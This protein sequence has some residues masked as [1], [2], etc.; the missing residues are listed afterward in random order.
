M[1]IH[2]TLSG[3]SIWFQ[4]TKWHQKS[5]YIKPCFI[6]RQKFARYTFRL[7]R[8]CLYYKHDRAV[9]LCQQMGCVE[10]YFIVI[11][12]ID[13]GCC[14]SMRNWLLA[15]WLHHTHISACFKLGVWKMIDIHVGWSGN[16]FHKAL[17]W[18]TK[19]LERNFCRN[20]KSLAWTKQAVYNKLML[21]FS[22]IYK[23]HCGLPGDSNVHS[24]SRWNK[25]LSAVLQAHSAGIFHFSFWKCSLVQVCDDLNLVNK[26]ADPHLDSSILR[27]QGF[28][29]SYLILFK[30][31]LA[32]TEC[33]CMAIAYWI[34]RQLFFEFKKKVF[35]WN[36]TDRVK[37][38]SRSAPNVVMWR[39]LD[40]RYLKIWRWV[41]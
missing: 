35:Q 27:N 3:I 24:L 19:R 34:F 11:Q 26:L 31:L 40:K 32:D 2:S 5:L 4:V 12:S 1:Y 25:V 15:K 41:S 36:N 38:E 37:Q 14:I 9:Q 39:N 18:V 16:S 33:F 8:A 22:K 13:G 23:F 21:F 20:Y 28:Q 10:H 30:I 7:F 17:R 29:V 6:T